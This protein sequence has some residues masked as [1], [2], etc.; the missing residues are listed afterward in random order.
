MS[1]QAYTGRQVDL[2][3]VQGRRMGAWV[4][5]VWREKRLACE[6]EE[7]ICWAGSQRKCNRESL[8]HRTARDPA[9]VGPGTL[10]VNHTELPYTSPLQEEGQAVLP[11]REGFGGPRSWSPPRGSERNQ[12]WVQHWPAGCSCRM[13]LSQMFASRGA[14][15]C[16]LAALG[17]RWY[18]WRARTFLRSSAS[19]W[20]N[21]SLIKTIASCCRL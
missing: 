20:E 17:E 21:N 7:I 19:P 14:C 1:G 10:K 11:Q 16:H 6:V 5:P 13:F 8:G 18:P 12:W 2:D 15:M 3:T 9:D 4:F